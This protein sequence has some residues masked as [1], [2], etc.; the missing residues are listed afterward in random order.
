MATA[1]TA[2]SQFTTKLRGVRDTFEL[3]ARHS[4]A[5]VPPQWQSAEEKEFDGLEALLA[6]GVSSAERIDDD[7]RLTDEGKHEAR[8]ALLD[9]LTEKL[10]PHRTRIGVLDQRIETAWRGM[11]A[12]SAAA[13]PRDPSERL[14]Y[15]LRGREFRDRLDMANVDPLV[16]DAN[17]PGLT[18]EEASWLL[19]A[20]PRVVKGPKG[21]VQFLP[22][23]SKAAQLNRAIARASGDQNSL[24]ADLKLLRD[25]W[26]V[27][28]GGV[29]HQLHALLPPDGRALARQAFGAA[30]P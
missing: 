15:E 7:R 25:L 20:P 26:T 10:A 28:L 9:S 12:G 11:H 8:R 21:E 18:D 23:V 5:T 4:I 30:T 27:T 13:L 29:E 3:Q 19:H 14:T 1:S 2:A 6:G 24:L 16:L 22:W 17:F